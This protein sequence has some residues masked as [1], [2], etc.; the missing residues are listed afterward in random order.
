MAKNDIDEIQQFSELLN[1][2][3]EEMRRTLNKVIAD[4]Q[5]PP[6]LVLSM[7]ARLAADYTHQYQRTLTDLHDKDKV[8]DVF[9]ENYNLCLYDF[10]M[11]DINDVMK[12]MEKE[13]LN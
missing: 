5:L 12:E 2:A 11:H 13:H 6:Q 4:K 8:E 7:L 9:I 1:E 10:D 3:S